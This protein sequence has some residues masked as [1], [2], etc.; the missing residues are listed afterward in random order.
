MDESHPCGHELLSYIFA[1]TRQYEKAIAEAELAIALDPNGADGHAAL[2]YALSIA[3]RPKEAIVLINKAIRSNPI[4][5]AYY[6]RLLGS[7]YRMTDRNEEAIAA[8][9]KSLERSPNDIMTHVFLTISYSLS[10]RDDEARAQ[11][12]EVLRIQPKFSVNRFV[13]KLPYKDKS[14]TQRSIDALRKAGL[15]D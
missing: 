4:A 1:M 6:F 14:E 9:K 8:Y 13:K 11:A 3:G 15:P 12:K 5:P 2:G 10:D 7:A